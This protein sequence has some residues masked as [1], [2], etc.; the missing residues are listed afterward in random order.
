MA[1]KKNKPVKSAPI[2]FTNNPFKSLKGLSAFEEHSG[3]SSCNRSGE[4]D[5]AQLQTES[6]EESGSF[7]DEMAFLGVK[8]FKSD[9]HES[10]ANDEMNEDPATAPGSG[11]D[12]S[13]TAVFLNAVTQMEKV[14]KEEDYDDV[15]EKR[16]VPRRMKQ[17]ERGQLIPEDELDLHGLSVDEAKAKVLFFLQ[18]A[19][20]RGFG[21]VLLITGR[22]LH[23]AS[24][25]VLRSAI[26]KCL[27]ENTE[28]VVEW[29]VAPR[30]Y[31][32]EGALVIFLRQPGKKNP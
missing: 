22:G 24:G 28:Q 29:G 17:V 23:S 6:D 12:E 14:F 11:G 5:A 1:K 10:I 27:R 3:E 18:N 32:G 7:A 4:R 2:D 25:P 13:D 26:E 31:G 8:Q 15:Q 20:Y 19:I 30:R 9:D 21:T 16:A